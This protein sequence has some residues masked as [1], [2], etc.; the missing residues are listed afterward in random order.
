LAKAIEWN[1]VLDFVRQALKK[2]DQV[3]LRQ[4][5]YLLVEA[6]LIENKESNY[7]A[8]SHILVEA[9]KKNKIN[10]SKILDRSRPRFMFFNPDT[11][12]DQKNYIELVIEKDT[13]S[14]F[15]KPYCQRYDI[16]L[17]VSRGYS[18]WTVKKEILD[19]ATSGIPLGFDHKII[20]HF[21]DFDPSGED[22]YR[23]L[24]DQI[25]AFNPNIEFVKALL[26]LEDIQ[27]YNLPPSPPK[28]S[29]TRTRA[30]LKKFGSYSV[31]VEA[32]DPDELKRRIHETIL[33]YIDVESR[34][35]REIEDLVQTEASKQVEEGLRLV[36]IML[37]KEVLPAIMDTLKTSREEIA[38]AIK[39]GQTVSLDYDQGF[40]KDMLAEKLKPLLGT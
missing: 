26:T 34:S 35:K 27:K 5:H 12:R 29:D 32:L 7:K 6:R 20:I 11:W 16:N 4:L 9:R 8:L 37:Y 22:L 13:L 19:R 23:D 25:K 1:K 40:V 21:G 39:T 3:T 14:G 2:Y 17:V 28:K 38:S 18:S 31:E 33:R 36:K 30:F 15:F 10:N 24:K